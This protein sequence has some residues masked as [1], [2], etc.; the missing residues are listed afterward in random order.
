MIVRCI[1]DTKTETHCGAELLKHAVFQSLSSA[2]EA[3]ENRSEIQ[4]CPDCLRFGSECRSRQ[5]QKRIDSDPFLE[6]ERP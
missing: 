2:F 3:V 4:P 6:D 5:V 1:K